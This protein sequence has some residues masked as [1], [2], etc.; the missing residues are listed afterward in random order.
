M[1]N[2]SRVRKGAWVSVDERLPTKDGMYDVHMGKKSDERGI[3]AAMIFQ[4]GKG[5]SVSVPA[6]SKSIPGEVL[7]WWDPGA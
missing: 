5:W 6:P 3:A 1:A 4:V 2:G 7:D